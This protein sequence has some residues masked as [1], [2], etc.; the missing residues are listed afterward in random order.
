MDFTGYVVDY[1]TDPHQPIPYFE[2]ATAPASLGDFAPGARKEA[3]ILAGLTR[4]VDAILAKE[5]RREDGAVLRV[6]KLLIDAR[7]DT[8]LVGAF[9]RRSPHAALLVPAMGFYV[10]KGKEWTGFFANKEGGQTGFHWRI[11]P[12]KNGR[13]Y[14]LVDTNWWKTLALERLRVAKG[15]HGGWCLFGRDLRDHRLLA[16]HWCSERPVW[17]EAKGLGR[18]EWE[19]REGRPDNHWWDCLVGCAVGASLSGVTIPGLAPERPRRRSPSE[20]PTARQVAMQGS[21]A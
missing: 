12:P 21:N 6:G 14:L 3:A 5:W 19:L 18:F 15:D 11:P 4:V 7:Y 10:P 2:Q 8:D 16:D 17:V 9:C 20:R 1:G 13:R